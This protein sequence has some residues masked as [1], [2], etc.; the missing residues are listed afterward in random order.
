MPL[1]SDPSPEVEVQ[2]NDNE[3]SLGL[4][5]DMSMADANKAFSQTLFA[6]GL[7]YSGIPMPLDRLP[8]RVCPTHRLSQV[9]DNKYLVDGEIRDWDDETQ[10]SEAFE[11]TG[12]L[13]ISRQAAWR[14]IKSQRNTHAVAAAHRVCAQVVSLEAVDV[15]PMDAEEAAMAKLKTLL[16]EKQYSCYVMRGLFIETSKRSHVTYI[17]R[18]GLPTVAWN[19][20]EGRVLAALCLHPLAYYQYSFAGSMV[21]TDDIIAHLILMRGDE[22][23][24]W[25]KCNQHAAERLESGI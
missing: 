4:T 14:L 11:N 5:T 23:R 2:E 8:L 12:N 13:L 22:R 1:P 21:P 24:F 17:F 20:R 9:L 19:W 10:P 16:S 6:A 18:R 15:Y 3:F 7:G 25:G